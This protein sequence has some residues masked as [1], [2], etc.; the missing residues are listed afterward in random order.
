M[1]NAKFI[2]AAYEYCDTHNWVAAPYIRKNFHLDFVPS[3]AKFSIASSGFYELFVNGR[4]ITKGELA[5]YISNPDHI[6]YEDVYDVSAL[7]RKGENVIGIMLGN[8]FANQCV[9]SWGYSN[10]SFR[11]PLCVAVCLVVQGEESKFIL[12]SDETFKAHPSPVLFDMYRWGIFYDARHEIENWCN[13][14]YDDHLW[15]NVHFVDGPKGEVKVCTAD[16]IKDQ[17]EMVP[18]SIKKQQDFYYLYESS[19]AEAKPFKET[20]VNEGWLYD[21]GKSRAGVCRLKI[22]GERGQK[23]TLRHCETLRDGNF[24]LNSIYTVREDYADYIHLFQTDTYILKGGEEEI[25]TPFFTYHGFRYVLVEGITEE[26][27]SEELLTFVVMNSDIRKRASFESSDETL[28]K[29]YEMGVHAD[30]SNFF[31]FPTDCPHREKNGWTGD[32]AVSAEQLLLTFD[33]S[34]SLRVWMENI[35]YAQLDSGMLPGIV[36]TAGWGYHWGNGPRWDSVITEIPYYAWKYDGRTD[37]IEENAEMILKYLDYI[38]GRRDER[39]LVK[40]GLGDWCQPGSD[41]IHISSPLEF[42]DSCMV[43]EMA[44]KTSLMMRQ[45]G[46]VEYAEKAEQLAQEMRIAIREYLLDKETMTAAGNCQ[47]SQALGLYLGLFEDEEYPVAYQKLIQLIE[48]KDRHVDCG[49]IGLRCI[50][51]VLFENGDGRLAYEMITREDEPSYGS[52]IKRGGTAL[53]ESL[54]A[55]GVQESQNHHFFGDILNLFVT[56]LAGLVINPDMTD[57]NQV[58]IKSHK[59]DE[60]EWV[61]ASYETKK[62]EYIHVKS[63]DNAT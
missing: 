20:Y 6:V 32:A 50:F 48:A 37:L 39:G 2:S 55:N 52:M 53:F 23:I 19:K 29:L 60:V 36:P 16:P 27:A 5:P 40:C 44:Q 13:P 26:Q 35:R 24:N 56:K 51:H 10:A 41:N 1:T 15:E 12:E 59:I 43:L 33:C 7:L 42:T 18:V 54:S 57:E 8:G 63:F 4:K 38:K 31:Y 9:T 3:E 11:A 14:E 17:Y 47:T 46:K 34:E 22:R 49:M 58:F 21:F 30:L 61:K 28:N 25:F 62:G 45:I